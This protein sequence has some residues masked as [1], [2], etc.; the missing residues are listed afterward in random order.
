MYTVGIDTSQNFLLLALLED[1]KLIDSVQK[2]CLKQQS[3]L[4]LPELD[5]LLTKHGLKALDVDQWVITKGPGSYT[6]VRIAMTLAK[7]MGSIANREVYTLSTLQ[8]YAGLQECYVIM[9]ARAKRV[10][11]G[12]YKDG[13]A[14]MDDTIYPN[15]Q[16][17]QI[18][19]SGEPVVGDLHVFGLPDKYE[20]LANN[21]V[22]LK[23]QWEKVDNID[24]LTPTYLKSNAEYMK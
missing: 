23:E 2:D 15:E 14:V 18:I 9:D 20:H 7:V 17:L 21:F 6:G 12:K 24:L 11:V 16:M 13:K 22:L 4:L 19:N 1:G 10:Y 3:E 5:S 8:L